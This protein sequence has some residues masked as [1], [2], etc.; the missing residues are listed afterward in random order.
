M[1]KLVTP[2]KSFGNLILMTLICIAIFIVFMAL[3]PA[4]AVTAKLYAPDTYPYPELT[5][6]DKSSLAAQRNHVLL[7]PLEYD[8]PFTSGDLYVVDVEGDPEKMKE[9]CKILPPPAM[10]KVRLGCT[11]GYPLHC[12]IIHMGTDYISKQGYTLNIVMRH[13]IGHCN[14]WVDSHEKARLWFDKDNPIEGEK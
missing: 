7:P 5:R 9:W 13:E 6:I 14:G 11:I 4:H 12:T 10:G 8:H 1:K 2:M 3:R